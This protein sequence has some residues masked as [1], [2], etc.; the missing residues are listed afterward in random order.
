MQRAGGRHRAANGARIPNLGQQVA[1]FTTAEGHSCSLRFQIAGVERPL[2]SVSQLAR[3][4]HTVEFSKDMAVVTHRAS[5]R[6]LKLPRVG[7]VYVI[8][9]RVRDATPSPE[10]PVF[11]RPG[12]Q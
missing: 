1:A 2:V 5:G 7:G 9:M 3:T 11:S 12:K 4:G 10:G 6:K 8:K